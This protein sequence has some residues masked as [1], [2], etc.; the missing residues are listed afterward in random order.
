MDALL[1]LAPTATSVGYV[2]R[3]D[4]AMD[5]AGDSELVDRYGSQ[6]DEIERLSSFDTTRR[7]D[8]ADKLDGNALPRPVPV[9]R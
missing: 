4:F 1:L 7:I 6:H 5:P 8:T 9:N 2:G 3:G